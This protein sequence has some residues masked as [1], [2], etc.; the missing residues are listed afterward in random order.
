MAADPEIVQA[1]SSTDLFAGVG[2]KALNAIA[3][4]A[5]VVNH[6]EGKDITEEGGGAAGFHLIRSGDVSVTVHGQPRKDLG[7]GDYFG[8][9][10]MIDGKPRSAT[11]RAKTPVT[12][13][14]LA[15]WAFHPILDDHPD[16]A[17]QL[18]RVMCER[19]RAAEA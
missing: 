13:I 7:A 10:S 5:R 19:L 9:I 12:T 14:A 2:K 8:E 3:A 18:L 1:L 16:V 15:S 4:Q 17:K 6:P 11:V